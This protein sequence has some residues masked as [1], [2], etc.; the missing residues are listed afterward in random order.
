MRVGVIRGDL[1]GPLFMADL[2]PVSQQDFPVENYGQTRYVSRPDPTTLTNYLSG[3]N[4]D[5]L[6]I[7]GFAGVPAG[8]KGTAAPS[9]LVIGA[10]NHVLRI[11]TSS[12]A[13]YT[14]VSIAQ[15]TYASLAALVAAV[16]TALVA[17]GITATATVDSTGTVFVLVSNTVGVGSYISV[18]TVGAGSTFNTPVQLGAGGQTFTMASA[19]TIITALL[20]VGGPL[21]VSASSLLTN[22]G[23]A[24]TAA[25]VADKIAPRFIETEQ[26]VLSFQVGNLSKYLESTFT[27]DPNRLPALAQSA[28]IT[29]VQDD[30]TTTFTST[31]PTVSGAVHNSPNTGDLTIA[32]TG[33]GNSEFFNATAVRVTNPTTGVYVH[34]EQRV[35]GRTVS[36]GTTGSVSATSI[37]I[38]ASLLAGLGVVGSKVQVKYLSLASAAFTAT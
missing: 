15:T 14:A 35:I 3:L 18:D 13:S 28:A 25:S 26:A 37:V 17:A 36:G 29:V 23:A 20:P 12:G 8:I 9:T 5:G 21:N 2:E 31:N 38:P 34:L 11:K 19:S 4:N 30:G 22:V 7:P 24:P 32:G 33:L 6:A 27:P 10:G 1:P 16:N